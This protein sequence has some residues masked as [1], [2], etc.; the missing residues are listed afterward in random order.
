MHPETV[1]RH[2]AGVTDQPDFDAAGWPDLDVGALSEEGRGEYLRRKAA[3][4]LYLSGASDD[5]LRRVHGLGVRHL[6]RLLR[7]R[8][9]APHADGGIFGWR[10][11]VKHSRVKV[12]VRQASVKPGAGGRGSAGAMGALLR[13]EP[14]FAQRLER[15]ILKTCT[16]RQLGESRRPRHAVWAW[17]LAELRKLGYEIRN[18]WPFTVETMAYASVVRLVDKTLNANPGRAV[19][20]VGGPDGEKK[21]ISGDGVDRPP[22]PPF[23]R[24]EM[25]AH[26]L[27]CRICILMP[28]SSGGWAP[29]IVHRLWVTVI[30]E[31]AS[32]AVLGYRL[33]LGLEV[34]KDDVLRTIKCALSP[35]QRPGISYSQVAL[36]DEAALPSSHHPDYVGLCWDE[37]SVDGALAETCKTVATKLQ[38]VVASQLR[39]PAS[40]Y[41]ARRSKDDRPFVETFFRTL[42]VRGLGRLSNSTGAK[43]G[44]K[45]GRDPDAVA[46]ASQFQLPYLEELLAALIANYNA[47]PHAGLGYRSPLAQLDYFRSAGQLPGRRA[48]QNLVQGLL[49]F[50]K[51]CLVR[52]GYSQGKAPYVNFQGVRYSNATLA[53]RHDLV[54]KRIQVVNHLEDDARIALACTE[55]G[56]TL[57][58]L[59]AAPPWH[60]LPHS[61]AIR[62]SIQSMV[63]RRMFAVA[64]GGDAITAFVEYVQSQHRG[65]LPVHP[66]YLAVQSVLAQHARRPDIA[67]A[68]MDEARA[69]LNTAMPTTTPSLATT[70]SEVSAPMGGAGSKAGPTNAAASASVAPRPPGKSLPTQRRAANN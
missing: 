26:K 35:W 69:K 3:I 14:D 13:R 62:S 21:M 1:G 37:T 6:N 40:G 30:L 68:R 12:Y 46:L 50:R 10:G 59:R 15:H 9:L 39:S 33:S 17:F 36:M 60:V 63:R 8:C 57:G 16:D 45:Q 23:R 53:S 25:D 54:G 70:A 44:D 29:K 7:E 42:S 11:L 56:M 34:N 31:V 61:L 41:S 58:V 4:L 48:D 65:R 43:P 64:S 18:E 47:T 19:R 24:V 38:A 32:R 22:L 55:Q 5:E 52:G 49:S 27:D 66:T 67:A 28:L 51:S 20:V 2:L